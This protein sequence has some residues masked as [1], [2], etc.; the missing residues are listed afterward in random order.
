MA[1]TAPQI[2]S[3]QPSERIQFSMDFSSKMDSG[4]TIDNIDFV[5]SETIGGG[6]SDLTI[7]G[8]GVTGQTV[9]MWISGGSKNRYRIETKISTSSTAILEGDGILKVS[10][11]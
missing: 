10:D 5:R 6:T 4:E 11:K 3:K 2:L 8:T 1:N 7:S 9:T